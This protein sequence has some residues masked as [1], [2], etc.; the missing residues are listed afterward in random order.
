M[1]GLIPWAR[2]GVGFRSVILMGELRAPAQPFPMDLH[3]S[4]YLPSQGCSGTL[5]MS[6]LPS[7]YPTGRWSQRRQ[8]QRSPSLWPTL[9]WRQLL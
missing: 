5:Q 1:M 3:P 7:L 6:L 4:L 9:L 8:A 2:L